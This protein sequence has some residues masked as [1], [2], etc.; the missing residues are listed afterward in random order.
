MVTFICP[1]VSFKVS[2]AQLDSRLFWKESSPR[3]SGFFKFL[4]GCFFFRT[5]LAQTFQPRLSENFLEGLLSQTGSRISRQPGS[6]MLGLVGGFHMY[7]L[8]SKLGYLRHTDGLRK[9]RFTRSLADPSF[10]TPCC[11]SWMLLQPP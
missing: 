5:P 8:P 11:S 2:K 9:Q 4:E 1:V 10:G 7:L 3:Y 6:L